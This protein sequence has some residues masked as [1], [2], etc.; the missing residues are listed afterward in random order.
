MPS[1][2]TSSGKL[3]QIVLPLSPD[4]TGYGGVSLVPE[5]LVAYKPSLDVD[6]AAHRFKYRKLQPSGYSTLYVFSPL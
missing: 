6:A 4:Y 2:A 1:E 3:R 5:A